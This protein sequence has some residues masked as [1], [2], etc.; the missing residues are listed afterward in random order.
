MEDKL[1]LNLNQSLKKGFIDKNIK[2]ENNLTPKLL[3]NNKHQNVLT[4]IINE[5]EKCYS[6]FISVAFITESGLASLKTVL[7][8]LNHKGIKGKLITSNY[9][10]F[11]T[12]KM[13]RELLKLNNVEVRLTDI[14]GFHSKGYIFNHKN[15][16][17]MIIGSSNLTSTAMKTNYEHNILLSTHK[18][19][20][21]IYNLM[22]QFDNLWENSINLNQK[23]I[24]DYEEIFENNLYNDFLKINRE[25]NNIINRF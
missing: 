22:N 6:F 17:S 3:I 14:E 10:G 16:S 9:L 11:N 7:D 4:S 5:L 23:W 12:P 24:N 18:N 19:G 25:Q 8:D 15:Y 13:Y 20:E 1:I 21:L 2:N